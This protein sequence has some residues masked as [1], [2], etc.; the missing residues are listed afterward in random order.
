MALDELLD[1]SDLFENT[2]FEFLTSNLKKKKGSKIP[3]SL[4]HIDSFLDSYSNDFQLISFPNDTPKEENLSTSQSSS[5]SG[6]LFNTISSPIQDRSLSLL[7]SSNIKEPEVENISKLESNPYKVHTP[8][9]RR[10]E[11]GRDK[12][13]LC[14]HC[15]KQKSKFYCVECQ[16]HLCIDSVGL[17]NCWFLHHHHDQQQQFL[18]L[19]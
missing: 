13:Q 2:T 7:D 3:S 1:E 19:S 12:R 14:Y 10:R 18:S 11:L 9:I 17:E 16:V 6:I 5:L 8:S 15:H 4:L